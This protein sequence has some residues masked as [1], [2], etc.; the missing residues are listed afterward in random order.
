MHRIPNL[1][2]D[3]CMSVYAKQ[4]QE[5]KH[6]NRQIIRRKCP[7]MLWKC[8]N[9][10]WS[11]WGACRMWRGFLT[12][13]SCCLS[14]WQSDRCSSLRRS[15]TSPGA[16][17][18]RN[19]S[20]FLGVEHLF[21]SIPLELLYPLSISSS[22]PPTLSFS[23]SRLSFSCSS[24]WPKESKGLRESAVSSRL[25][26]FFCSLSSFRASSAS[27]SWCSAISLKRPASSCCALISSSSSSLWVNSNFTDSNSTCGHKSK[28][29]E[30]DSLS[31]SSC[32][33]KAHLLHI[34]SW[35]AMCKYFK[36][37]NI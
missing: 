9:S 25:R 3:I 2:S 19:T 36:A 1:Q 13:S 27:S 18:L 30:Y 8:C 34:T 26:L 24:K 37:L 10:S 17:G 7:V 23:P 12:C 11:K 21:L 31:K 6:K 5:G 28:R 33:S 20:L 15:A 29:L 16:W 14:F 35:K 32:S 22:S 4:G